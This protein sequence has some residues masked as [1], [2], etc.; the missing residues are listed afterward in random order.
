MIFLFSVPNI[1]IG[2]KTKWS[3]APR[4]K[5]KKFNVFIDTMT[6]IR[7]SKTVVDSMYS[8]DS[9]SLQVI[10][11]KAVVDTM[12]WFIQ[13]HENNGLPSK[14]QYAI[15]KNW[16]NKPFPLTGL[17]DI[18]GKTINKEDFIGKITIVNCWGTTCP[19]CIK[20]IPY[21]NK[22]M[23]DLDPNKHLCIALTSNSKTEIEKYFQSPLAKKIHKDQNP[24]FDFR[25]IPNQRHNLSKVLTVNSYPMTFFIDRKGIIQEIK[26]GFPAF[27]SE[28]EIA[29]YIDSVYLPAIEKARLVVPEF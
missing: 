27:D 20:E 11:S 19:P 10:S 23:A 26:V 24:Q 18:H 2:Q 8:S 9:Q 13:F 25:V 4:F 14:W 21:L 16:L 6:E 12:F 15:D 17:V 5:E 3:E 1:A 28:K 29:E 7:Y 22:I